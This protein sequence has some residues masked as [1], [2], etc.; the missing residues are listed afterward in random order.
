MSNKKVDIPIN[1]SVMSMRDRTTGKAMTSEKSQTKK[2]KEML[3]E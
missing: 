1:L 3:N 2:A